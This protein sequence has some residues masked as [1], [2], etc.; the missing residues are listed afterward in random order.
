MVPYRLV[1]PSQR[2]LPVVSVEVVIKEEAPEEEE[3]DNKHPPLLDLNSLSDGLLLPEAELEDKA[4][5]ERP[6]LPFL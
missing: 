5:R 2:A 3:E 4:G 1:P 6:L